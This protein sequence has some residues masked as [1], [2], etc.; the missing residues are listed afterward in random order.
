MSFRY[1]F[2]LVVVLSLF[3]FGCTTSSQSDPEMSDQSDSETLRAVELDRKVEAMRIAV[4]IAEKSFEC[5]TPE[6]DLCLS[7]IDKSYRFV[8]ERVMQGEQ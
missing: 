2:A 6:F 3:T 8:I 5:K 4:Q 7:Q 1:L